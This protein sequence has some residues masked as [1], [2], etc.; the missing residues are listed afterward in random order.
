VIFNFVYKKSANSIIF[1]CWAN[2]VDQSWS[3]EQS[4]KRC[5][6]FSFELGAGKAKAETLTTS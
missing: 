3:W 4:T 1:R 6:L 2:L 5:G